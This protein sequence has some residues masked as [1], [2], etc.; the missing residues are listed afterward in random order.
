MSAGTPTLGTLL[1]HLIEHLD[2]AVEQAYQQAGLDYR[3][4][5]TPVIRA[6]MAQGPV[7]LR[8]ISREARISHSAVSQT[9]SQMVNDGLVELQPGS[10]GRE[11]IVTLTPRARA[12]LPALERQWSAT[13]AAAERL[14]AELSAPLSGI[15][16]E[17][18][19][20][21][22]REPFDTRIEKAAAELP[23]PRR[24]S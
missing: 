3:P 17:A 11:R 9:V 15:L 10:D 14:D 22:E 16:R 7:S 18:L 12:M 1:R 21:L 13:N 8:V 5:Y 24:R 2:G 6:L 19:E 4:R 23:K 20:A